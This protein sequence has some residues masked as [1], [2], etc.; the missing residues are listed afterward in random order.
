MDFYSEVRKRVHISG[1]MLE[2]EGSITQWY[3]QPFNNTKGAYLQAGYPT[4]GNAGKVVGQ[5]LKFNQSRVPGTFAIK[6][7][8]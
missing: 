7:G 3:L 1:F 5:L 4:L 2:F 6:Y 8:L